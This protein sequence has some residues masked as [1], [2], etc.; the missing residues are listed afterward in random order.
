MVDGA[1]Y[2]IAIKLDGATLEAEDHGLLVPLHRNL[3][4]KV[5]A[6]PFFTSYQQIRIYWY[7]YSVYCTWFAT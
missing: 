2:G 3:S 5:S 1:S 4:T 6:I 7:D